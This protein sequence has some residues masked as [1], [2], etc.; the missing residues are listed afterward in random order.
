KIYATRVRE[1][2]EEMSMRAKG[3]IRLQVIDPEPFSEEEDRA[4]ELGLSPVPLGQTG[5]T[6][7]FGL[8]GTNSTDGKA[9][10][11]VFHPDKEEFLEYDIA[12]LIVEL[13]TPKKPVLGLMST[14]PMAPDYNP[15]TGQQ[16]E[17]WVILSQLQQLFTVQNISTT[18]D[19]I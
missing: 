11:E 1:L 2:L 7:Y 18:A 15:Q 13:N 6:L 14:L 5:Q 12:K 3:K 19:S 10:I 17:G 16:R 9:T 4:S 8:A